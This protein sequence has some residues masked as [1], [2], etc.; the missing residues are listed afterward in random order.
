MEIT[1][2]EKTIKDI[3]FIINSIVEK[4][5]EDFTD[6]TALAWTLDTLIRE[7]EALKKTMERE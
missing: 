5:A 1:I 6:V 4:Y 7:K 3:D 2:D